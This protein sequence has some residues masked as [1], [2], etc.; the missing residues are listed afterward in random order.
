[1]WAGIALSLGAVAGE[2][3]VAASDG[4]VPV[5][6]VVS[7][8]VSLGSYQAGFLY[9]LTEA[10][11]R[12]PDAVEIKVL[13]GTSA[14]SIN[15][16]LTS[17][18]SCRPSV[19]D[20]RESLFYRTWIPIGFDELYQ[21]ADVT[22]RSALSRR[23]FGIAAAQLQ[24]E[25]S[26]GIDADCTRHLGFTTT[27]IV[28]RR[29]DIGVLSDIPLSEER[30]TVDVVGEG[31]GALPS[32][33]ST[34]LPGNPLPQPVLPFADHPNPYGL[35]L[36][37][38]FASS[39]FPLAFEP[40]EVPFCSTEGLATQ[41]PD[42][43]LEEAERVELIDGALFDNTPLR[44]AVDLARA[45]ELPSGPIALLPSDSLTW[46][47]PLAGGS[48]VDPE[49]DDTISLV[50]AIGQ[51]FVE[52]AQQ[53]ELRTVADQY[54]EV[55]DQL[56]LL[57]G[58][59]PSH[60]DPLFAFGGFFEQGFREADF[61]QGMA[62]AH[63]VVREVGPEWAPGPPP[64]G[65]KDL[66]GG[67]IIPRRLIA[68]RPGWRAFDC[69]VG[70]IDEDEPRMESCRHPE[71]EPLRA[72]FQVAFDR[73]YAECREL[74]TQSMPSDAIR[75]P[76]CQAAMKG[77]SPV[78]VPG[79]PEPEDE[80]WWRLSHEDWLDHQLRRLYVHGFTWP[81]EGLGV[82]RPRVARRRLRDQIA[83]P[84][85]A[86]SEGRSSG[87]RVVR[88]LT[89]LGLNQLSYAPPGQLV[90]V[91]VGAQLEGGWS[92]RLGRGAGEWIRLGGA[93]AF[94]G[95]TSPFSSTQT[96]LAVTP[97]LDVQFEAVPLSSGLFQP[98][99]G[100][101]LGFRF[102]T[103]DQLGRG[104]CDG[105]GQICTQPAIRVNASVSF[106]QRLRAS[107]GLGFYQPFGDGVPA[108]VQVLPQIAAQF[109]L[110]R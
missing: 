19:R 6:I 53:T 103:A 64:R 27:R 70:L 89:E 110:R 96:F 40:V 23:A 106:A 66:E 16:V 94:D 65:G 12:R 90:F 101:Q 46:P 15:A 35:L 107:F 29:A 93:V 37:V 108:S 85:Y 49:I 1:M 31:P 34:V 59:L 100:V 51:G 84:A 60:G 11:R 36:D 39:A 72:L 75:D 97:L 5:S 54:P 62:A 9:Y 83:L 18:A 32:L 82:A 88:L 92:A 25:L 68:E 61:V 67:L 80:Q 47:R 10:L 17:L 30:F 55:L 28:P 76:R 52:T 22:P 95:L 41:V 109:P 57:R 3:P 87:N 24:H 99:L 81:D 73:L 50:R 38:V 74:A 33:R 21:E 4:P 48:M 56:T 91:G 20:P 105:A 13:T 26:A 102:S 77:A 78:Q 79:L 63:V 98:R 8:G 44:L 71:V 14:G 45:Q 58:L 43:S 104:E 42:C 69:L 7:G 2:D 86:L